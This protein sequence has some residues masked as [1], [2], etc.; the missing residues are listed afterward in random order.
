MKIT[1]KIVSSVLVI[2]LGVL[3]LIMKRDVITVAMT[4]LGA[5]LILSGLFDIAGKLI[6][7][8]VVKIV[9]GVLFIIF[10]FTIFSAVLYI[11]AALL[12]IWGIVSLYYRIRFRVKGA[13]AID[14]IAAYAAPVLGIV[15]A[16]LLFFNQ[17]GTVD[18]VFIGVGIFLILEGIISFF[19]PSRKN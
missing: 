8:A 13:R 14:T 1:Q 16:F 7:S 15:I 11:V 5:L 19:I 12:L 2:V 4:L 6:P 18:W 17:G 10:G 9:V 3:C